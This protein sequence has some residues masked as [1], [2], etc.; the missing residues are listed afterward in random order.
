MIG[1][2]RGNVSHQYLYKRPNKIERVFIVPDL[3]PEVVLNLLLVGHAF[4]PHGQICNK[5]V[6]NESLLILL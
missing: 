6:G 4:Q 1:G 5:P 3:F 2:F